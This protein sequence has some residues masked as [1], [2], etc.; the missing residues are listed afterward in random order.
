MTPFSQTKGNFNLATKEFERRLYNGDIVLSDDCLYLCIIASGTSK[1]VAPSNT[2]N[3]KIFGKIY[4]NE[5]G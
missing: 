1:G 2:T 4:S 5:N 3:W